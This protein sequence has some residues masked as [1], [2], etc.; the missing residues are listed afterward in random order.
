MGL[1]CLAQS[2]PLIIK[3][4]DESRSKPRRF[5]R[6][7]PSRVANGI[8]NSAF[9]DTEELEKSPSSCSKTSPERITDHIQSGVRR[10]SPNECINSESSS[11]K[12]GT[13]KKVR[14]NNVNAKSPSKE[15]YQIWMAENP[16]VVEKV[17]DDLEEAPPLPPR[18]LHRPLERSH[19]LPVPPV[20]LR[21]QKPKKNILKPEDSFGFELIDVDEPLI[22]NSKNTCSNI[23]DD[24][25]SLSEKRLKSPKKT[26][27]SDNYITTV[28]PKKNSSPKNVDNSSLSNCSSSSED[29]IEANPAIKPHKP[30]SR[31]ISNASTKFPVDSVETP[32]H[33]PLQK[34]LSS[35]SS[36][37]ESSEKKE[38]ITNNLTGT[39]LRVPKKLE[40]LSD[41]TPIHR[42]PSFRA[43]PVI[44]LRPHPKALE[45]VAGIASNLPICPPTPTHHA[46]KIRNKEIFKPPSLKSFDQSPEFEIVTSPEIKH[47]DIRAI[48]TL[49][50]WANSK[51][52]E[53][54]SENVCTCEKLDGT[55]NFHSLDT[56]DGWVNT[57]S[58]GATSECNCACKAN[59]L[60]ENVHKTLTKSDASANFVP[61]RSLDTIDGWV[62]TKSIENSS[63]CNCACRAN[64]LSENI[65]KTL[66][67]A[68]GTNFV[69][70]LHKTLSKPSWSLKVGESSLRSL[71]DLVNI[72]TRPPDIRS[73]ELSRPSLDIRLQ[74]QSETS[75]EGQAS[76]GAI[77]LPL[78]H[79]TSTRL[80]SIPERSPR[81]ITLD[82][83]HEEP[84]PPCKLFTFNIL[85]PDIFTPL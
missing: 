24:K 19:A 65:H 83:E 53:N 36:S 70:E 6:V 79:L 62:N 63:E 17:L 71:G 35:D 49:D 52:L 38:E 66:V 27:G 11:I 44:P 85:F 55:S 2:E 1:S 30:L 74:E 21:H 77:P 13:K 54:N 46:R 76:G 59:R 28:L 64:K 58:L 67:K 43:E 10:K 84:L 42:V 33:K 29:T 78:R 22:F 69:P 31:Q 81:V 45:R 12:G 3:E 51:L 18:A 39:P 37:S 14:P 16:K 9:Q 4:P 26:I 15:Y 20:V 25:D 82:S 61:L 40:N 7:K 5:V 50:G 23:L 56:L 68:D 73:Q 75:M 57:K 8:E 47:A 34:N 32:T 41:I 80:P 72:D 48:D 60:S